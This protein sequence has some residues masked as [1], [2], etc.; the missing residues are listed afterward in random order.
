VDD[1]TDH[2]GSLAGRWTTWLE[3]GVVHDASALRA[4]LIE[5]PDGF[6]L[7]YTGSIAGD[8]VVGS[9]AITDDGRTIEW[10]DSW[11]TAGATERLVASDGRP[12]SYRYG[13]LDAPWT[14]S[15]EI[16]TS[17]D[18]L[19]ITHHNAPPGGRPE[20]AVRMSLTGLSPGS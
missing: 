2:I 5:R 17:P 15:I 6:T 4:D 3:P 13:P 7:T 9:M 19:V 18:G 8:P 20:P 16:A 1:L 11:H 12:P 14:W 10:T